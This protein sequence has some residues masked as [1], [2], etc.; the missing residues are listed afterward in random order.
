MKIYE[1]DIKIKIQTLVHTQ[2]CQY[3]HINTYKYKCKHKC[4]HKHKCKYKST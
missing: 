3:E 1:D 4:K 2:K